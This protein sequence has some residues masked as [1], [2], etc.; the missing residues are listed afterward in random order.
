MSLTEKSNTRSLNSKSASAA[1]SPDSRTFKRIA[2]IIDDPQRAGQVSPLKGSMLLDLGAS[3]MATHFSRARTWR[4][5]TRH[6]PRYPPPDTAAA[7]FAS[8]DGRIGRLRQMNAD[9]LEFSDESFDC[10]LTISTFEHFYVPPQCSTRC[11]AC[12]PKALRWQFRASVPPPRA[13]TCT[14]LSPNELAHLEPFF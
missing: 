8:S 10:L 6:R 4:H 3:T 9:Q 14:T 1:K 5:F 2:R 7:E 12:P 13:T 11:F